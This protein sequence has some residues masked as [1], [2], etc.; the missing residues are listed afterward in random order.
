MQGVPPIPLLSF[1]NLAPARADGELDNSPALAASGFG[2]ALFGFGF[3]VTGL[4]AS[5]GGGATGLTI[6]GCEPTRE[7]TMVLDPPG[8]AGPGLAAGKR[9]VLVVPGPP[10]TANMFCFSKYL[11]TDW[12]LFSL[13]PVALARSLARMVNSASLQTPVQQA[14]SLNCAPVSFWILLVHQPGKKS[15]AHNG[16]WHLVFADYP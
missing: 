16:L 15:T 6:F 2:G 3:T 4:G 7:A 5:G 10:L 12:A 11:D 9:Y 1:D 13:R 8:C 14:A